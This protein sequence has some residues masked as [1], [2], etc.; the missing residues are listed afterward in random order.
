MRYFQWSAKQL[1]EWRPAGIFKHQRHAAVV[2]CQRDRSRG[3]AGFKFG[4]ERIFVLKSLDAIERG[5]FGCNK[6]HRRQ[7]VAGASV[8]SDVSLSQRREYIAQEVIHEGLLLG[9]H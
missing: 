9:G 7:A 5:F 8:E 3:P 6:Q 4:F 1:I 2:V